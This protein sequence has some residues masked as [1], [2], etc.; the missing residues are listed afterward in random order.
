MV[1]W[2]AAV[3]HSVSAAI[4]APNV[5]QCGGSQDWRR[6]ARIL[7]F[8]VR[9]VVRGTVCLRLERGGG[10]WMDAA[11]VEGIWYSNMYMARIFRCRLAFECHLAW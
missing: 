9:R 6:E 7:R 3:A 8:R 1:T 5:K 4:Y 10:R 11:G 2:N